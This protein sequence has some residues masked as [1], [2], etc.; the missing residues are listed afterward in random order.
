MISKRLAYTRKIAPDATEVLG[1]RNTK[2]SASINSRGGT[3]AISCFD[4]SPSASFERILQ[5][6]D[7][8]CDCKSFASMGVEGP[9]KK[10]QAP[11]NSNSRSVARDIRLPVT[12]LSGFLGAGKTR[13]KNFEDPIPK[14]I[15]TSQNENEFDTTRIAFVESR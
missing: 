3:W 5:C 12:V 4:T 14:W 9:M 6:L 10:P 8:F 13:W 1:A 7:R 15:S 2:N 11:S